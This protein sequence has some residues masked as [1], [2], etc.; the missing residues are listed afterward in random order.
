[1]QRK[2]GDWEAMVSSFLVTFGLLCHSS[3]DSS[4]SI[5]A[6]TSQRVL[7]TLRHT[8]DSMVFAASRSLHSPGQISYEF[9]GST[10]Q[11]EMA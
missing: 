7:F 3:R 5:L 9:S 11:L 6:A 8:G 1:M 2:D 10:M 4:A